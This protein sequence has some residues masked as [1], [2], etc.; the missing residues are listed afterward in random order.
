MEDRL[1][2]I[3]A[4]VV[5]F[6]KF[7]EAKNAALLTLDAGAIAAAIGWLGGDVGPP[8]WLA[9]AVKGGLALLVTS[10][11]V[12]LASFLPVLEIDWLKLK[13]KHGHADSVLYFGQIAGCTPAS[14]LAALR[15]AAGVPTDAAP[16]TRLEHDYAAQIVINAGIATA[17]FRLFKVG[18]WIAAAAVVV[19]ASVAAAQALG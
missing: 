11:L 10:G 1:E 18:A 13:R 8:D 12:A 14:Y 15:A 2:R 17:K 7:A 4:R 3:L 16:P 19:V 9:P 6:V 5:D